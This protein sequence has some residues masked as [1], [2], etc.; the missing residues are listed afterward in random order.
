[1]GRFFSNIQIKNNN[2]ATEFLNLFCEMMNENGFEMCSENEAAFSYTL[3]FS[4][5]GWVT[6]ISPM[7]YDNP[8]EAKKDSQEIVK[9]LKTSCFFVDVVDSK[10]AILKLFGE[11][12]DEV[13]IGDGS[14]YGVAE[15]SYGN[16][17]CWEQF[18]ANGNDW[19]QLSQIWRNNEEFVEDILHKSAFVFG[20]NPDYITADYEELWEKAEADK[21]INILHFKKIGTK[22]KPMTLEAAFIKVFGE[23]L[24]PLGFKKTNT[25]HPHFVRV[26]NDEIIHIITY[27]TDR[28][29]NITKS[30]FN[31]LGG[32]AT[33]YRDNID[34]SK[35]PF[36]E[37]ID[38]LKDNWWLYAVSGLDYDADFSEK[39]F[40][41]SFEK[42]N[43]EEMFSQLQYAFEVTSKI[44]LP[45]IS[46]A[47]DID[48]C[49]NYLLI[50]GNVN[51]FDEHGE[52][53]LFLKTPNYVSIIESDLK[54]WCIDFEN[55][56]DTQ[57]NR[58]SQTEYER[59]LQQYEDIRKS[60]ITP[61]EEILA[62]PKLL[63]KYAEELERRKAAN[64]EKYREYEINIQAYRKENND[65]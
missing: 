52:G 2:S 22:G 10:F 51:G 39:I 7:Y 35:N 27:R 24:E 3:A 19:E 53:M 59:Q 5:S 12:S 44:L 36:C 56:P 18:I 65:K 45:I 48:S 1:M 38:W 14:E 46:K 26:V 34:L 29:D 6:L 30:A 32:V 61:I 9:G 64:I 37:N 55:N 13:V 50:T 63:T 58:H 40:K 62:T 20:I 49:L 23:V 28:P 11:Y 47:I 33:V 60:K 16:R 8:H 17:K 4:E 43:Q 41:F 31:I 21:N 57:A 54:R 42:E 25:R 15:T